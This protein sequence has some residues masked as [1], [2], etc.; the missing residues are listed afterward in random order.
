MA[1]HTYRFQEYTVSPSRNIQTQLVPFSIAFFLLLI[2]GGAA[3][4]ESR[5][6]HK[7]YDFHYDVRYPGQ[8]RSD[9]GL[10]KVVEANA[11]D[12]KSYNR[13]TV[14]WWPKRGMDVIPLE[15]IPGA[16]LR[17]W[18]PRVPTDSLTGTMVDNFPKKPFKAHLIGFRGVGDGFPKD[19]KDP[20]SYRCPAAVL[21]LADGG[22]FQILCSLPSTMS[23]GCKG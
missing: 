20:T 10:D 13:R 21:R 11:A 3:D 15:D 16:P 17:T 4:A 18:T 23:V 2:A 5:K 12:L 22:I 7:E 1:R 9:V 14:Q 19:V 6:D 8:L